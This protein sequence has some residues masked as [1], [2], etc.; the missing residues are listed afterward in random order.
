MDKDMI[1]S[2][3]SWNGRINRSSST[4]GRDLGIWHFLSQFC[5]RR[6]QFSGDEAIHINIVKTAWKW[7]SQLPSC[8]YLPQLVR[9]P[10]SLLPIPTLVMY[11]QLVLCHLATV[12][13]LLFLRQQPWAF[14]LVAAL[15]VFQWKAIFLIDSFEYSMPTWTRS[16]Q[17][18]KIL[19][20]WL[21]KLWMIC[22]YEY[23]ARVGRVADLMIN[24]PF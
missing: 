6:L 21:Y 12:R 4:N 8:L 18:W 17:D 7:S 23:H 22:R 5:A 10:L 19:K 20:K 14:Q 9:T 1:S 11:G 16:S 15:P 2:L 3:Y 24:V 13:A